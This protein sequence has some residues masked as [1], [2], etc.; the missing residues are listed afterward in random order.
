[1]SDIDHDAIRA[2][3]GLL[4]QPAPVAANL[5]R[6]YADNEEIAAVSLYGAR[7]AV[8]RRLW[9]HLRSIVR[10]PILFEM[11][12]DEQVTRLEAAAALLDDFSPRVRR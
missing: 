6:A 10:D 7:A 9:S 3:F 5:L 12:D 11:T 2:A 1:M 8:T 4:S